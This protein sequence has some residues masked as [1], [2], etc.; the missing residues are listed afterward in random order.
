M[1]CY[2]VKDCV[3]GMLKWDPAHR[4]TVDEIIDHPWIKVQ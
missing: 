3:T 1:L 4:F 2:A